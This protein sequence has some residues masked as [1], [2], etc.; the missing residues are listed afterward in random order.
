[1]KIIETSVIAL[2][3]E[4]L[5]ADI[6]EEQRNPTSTTSKRTYV[7]KVNRTSKDPIR[8]SKSFKRIKNFRLFNRR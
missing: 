1:M 5:I 8:Q 7:H 3:L 4:F 2:N 6:L